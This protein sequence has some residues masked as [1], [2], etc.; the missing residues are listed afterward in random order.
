MLVG[1]Q[2][3]SD[4]QISEERLG[5]LDARLL[6]LPSSWSRKIYSLPPLDA[7]SPH[8]DNAQ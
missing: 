4:P 3:R 7:A 2:F 6:D 5:R 1:Q 8:T